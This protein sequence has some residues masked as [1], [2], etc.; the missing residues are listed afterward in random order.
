MTTKRKPNFDEEIK[1]LISSYR[2]RKDIIEAK[3]Q[4]IYIL[5]NNIICFSNLNHLFSLLIIYQMSIKRKLG[6]KSQTMLIR[7]IKTGS[8]EMLKT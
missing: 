2:E 8:S 7:S 1:V 6:K 3:V 4:P 5:N